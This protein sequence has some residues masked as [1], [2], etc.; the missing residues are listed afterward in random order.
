LTLMVEDASGRTSELQLVDLRLPCNET[1]KEGN[2]LLA[3]HAIVC[4]SCGCHAT[5]RERRA[6]VARALGWMEACGGFI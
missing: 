2:G 3:S 6:V 4:T 1:G 5:R